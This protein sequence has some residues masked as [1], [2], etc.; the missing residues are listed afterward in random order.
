MY[1]CLLSARTINNKENKKINTNLILLIFP[2]CNIEK[3]AINKN[4]EILAI[5]CAPYVIPANL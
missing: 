4:K 2:I 1:T 3:A 5:E